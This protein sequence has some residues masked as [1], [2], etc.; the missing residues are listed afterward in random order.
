MKGSTAGGH[1][2]GQPASGSDASRLILVADGNTGRGQRV[3]DECTTAGYPCKLAPHGAAAL[4]ISLATR[5]A[6][7]VAQLELPLVDALKL[8]EILR[9]NPRTRA[10]RFVFLGTGDSLGS[11]GAVGDRRCRRWGR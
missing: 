3:V 9:A 2:P 8:A 1:T 6:V 10:A 5:P 4:E 11:R 7:V